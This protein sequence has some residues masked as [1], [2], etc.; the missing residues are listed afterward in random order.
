MFRDVL[1]V[2]MVLKGRDIGAM[3]CGGKKFGNDFLTNGSFLKL[4]RRIPKMGTALS[5]RLW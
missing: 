5:K 2:I 3:G 4:Q 1:F